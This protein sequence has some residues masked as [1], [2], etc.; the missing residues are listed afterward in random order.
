MSPVVTLRPVE[1]AELPALMRIHTDPSVPGEFQW[2]GFRVARARELERRW[3][4]DGLIGPD[5][6]TL[7]I[8]LDDGT[9]AGV[10]TWRP[11]EATG[12]FEIGICVFPDHRG[13]GIGTEAQRQLVDHLFATTPANRVQAKTELGNVAEE[14]ALERIG[15]TCEGIL[16]GYG[17]RDGQWRDGVMY[18]LVRGD[19]R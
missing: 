10:V 13:H 17:F 12:N 5:S 6:S 16:R 2:F 8:A 7:A 4:E 3:A 18:G 11:V 9:L 1:Q 14:R 19:R 15:F